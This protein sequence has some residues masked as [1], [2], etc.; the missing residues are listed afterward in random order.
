MMCAVDPRRGKYLT[1]MANFRG[2]VSTREVDEQLLN[3]QNKNSSYFVDWIPNCVA[4][5]VCDVPPKGY[6]MSV[7][8]AGNCTA[9]S[10]MMRRCLDYYA[11][12]LRRKSF[13]HWYTGEG[14]NENEFNEA[15][16][17]MKD[18]INEYQTHQEGTDINEGDGDDE[19]GD[20][21]DDEGGY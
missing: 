6:K 10:G 12:L 21:E 3:V 11:A 9:I 15:E 4:T 16:Q 5:S 7:A 13:M 8:F 18:L 17:N 2:A 19:E 14:M 20:E 1:A